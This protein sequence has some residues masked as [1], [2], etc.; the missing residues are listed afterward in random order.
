ADRARLPARPALLAQALHN[1]CCP[2]GAAPLTRGARG[3]CEPPGTPITSR[4]SDATQRILHPI[5]RRAFTA[6][7]AVPRIGV[8]RVAPPP[9]SGLQP[10]R[11][12]GFTALRDL[13]GA[14]RGLDRNRARDRP[15]PGFQPNDRS[16][17]DLVRGPTRGGRSRGPTQGSSRRLGPGPTTG[18]G[19]PVSTPRRNCARGDCS[20][21]LAGGLF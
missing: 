15:P 1:P 8:P 13:H 6:R 3:S 17:A 5:A 16:P 19:C 18:P 20:G 12:E 11:D 21:L 14:S 9:R 4:T 10:F 2:L 7:R